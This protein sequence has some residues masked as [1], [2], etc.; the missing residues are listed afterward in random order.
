MLRD[1]EE[2]S[3][4]GEVVMM[5]AEAFKTSREQE[6]KKREEEEMQR[7][8]AEAYKKVL[9]RALSRSRTNCY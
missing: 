3:G 1:K 7:Q 8:E 5:E 6:K 9:M 4:V 2:M